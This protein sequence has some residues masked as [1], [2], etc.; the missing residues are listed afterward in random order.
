M[1]RGEIRRYTF[2]PPDKRR[3]VL[4]LTRDAVV[5]Q[6]N[7]I[8][9]V[10]VTRTVRGIST[11]VV[12]GPDDGMPVLCALNLDHVGIAQRAMRLTT[13]PSA[14]RQ[15]RGSAAPMRCRSSTSSQ[16]GRRV[17]DSAKHCPIWRFVAR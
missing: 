9:A 13:G 5:D 11:E 12:L 3:P 14:R 17:Q 8:V 4:I 1:N 10:P 6:L 15:R 2:R 16:L 7:E